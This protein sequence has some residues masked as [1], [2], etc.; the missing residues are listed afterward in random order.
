MNWVNFFIVCVVASGG[1]LAAT[2]EDV[3]NR[4]GL[5]TGLYFQLGGIMSGIGA[6][7][8]FGAMIL[9][10]FINPWWTIFMVFITAWF[11]SQFT[12]IIFKSFSQIISLILTV[13]GILLLFYLLILKY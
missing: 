11:I 1:F 9:S 2:Y 5:P 13:V 6:V 4:K 10:A 12:I 7:V 8:T 3:A